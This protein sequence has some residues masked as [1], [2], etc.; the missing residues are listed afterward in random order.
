MRPS[1]VQFP[2]VESSTTKGFSD[3][4]KLFPDPVATQIELLQPYHE[5]GAP[6]DHALWQLNFLSNFYKHKVDPPR[7]YQLPDCRSRQPCYS[8]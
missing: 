8:Y 2:I 6:Q 3:T 1:D 4:L 5:S 7:I